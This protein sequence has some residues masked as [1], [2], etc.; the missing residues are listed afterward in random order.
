[1][2]VTLAVLYLLAAAAAVA[3]AVASWRRRTRTPAALGLVIAMAGVAWWSVS[4]AVV[5]VA[6]ATDAPLAVGHLVLGWILPGASAAVTGFF[7]LGQWVV[8]RSWRPSRPVMVALGIEPALMLVAA[9]TNPW[10][11][12][13]V[14]DWVPEG[15]L[16]P[17]L[18][19]GWGLWVNTAYAYL[20]LLWAGARLLRSARYAGPRHRR[21]V[22]S[23]VLSGLLPAA[24]CAVTVFAPGGLSSPDLTA[25]CFLLTG[26]IDGYA[27]FRQGLFT[28]VPVARGLILDRLA[29]AVVVLDPDG[30][31]LDLNAA[32]RRLVDSL[33][34][35]PGDAG[36]DRAGSAGEVLPA[37][38][39]RTSGEH[40]LRLGGLGA[41]LDVRA[42]QL[43]DKRGSTIATVVLVRDITEVHRQRA[44][45][46]EAR[47][48][49]S[50]QALRDELTG[51]HNRRHLDAQLARDIAA[52][53]AGGRPLSVAM[54][55]LD[56]FKDVNDVL[57]HE[58]GDRVL[59]A[60]AGALARAVRS[61][62]TLARY[63]GEEFMLLLPD[64]DLAQAAARAEDLRRRCAEVR[65]PTEL[66]VASVTLSVGVATLDPS[67]K[68]AAADL[69]IAADRALYRA[70]ALGR[71]RVETAGPTDPE[72]APDQVS[73][74][75]RGD[76]P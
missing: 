49:L 46:D 25:V 5:A 75:P 63:G 31:V 33:S 61:G 69:L 53:R 39:P 68:S 3:L 1:V 30:R 29:D 67:G 44:A 2:H 20:M 71:D 52:A 60:V 56:H 15:G 23:L 74:A 40:H 19:P 66:G 12:W 36:G 64:A 32:G 21:Q 47:R 8:D 11:G 54:M 51:L 43:L 57:G 35:R 4:D 41:V 42:D 22:M 37:Q 59:T 70:K 16:W 45:L 13:T 55:D 7:L 76:R 24:G 18:V 27:V 58:V 48:Q 34:D 73:L 65:V 62:D 14:R 26:L 10:L 72:A 38:F 50:E 6:V 9:M 28:V 17:T